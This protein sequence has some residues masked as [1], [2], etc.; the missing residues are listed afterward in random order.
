[1]A[2]SGADLSAWLGSLLR[3]ARPA[4]AL[5]HARGDGS[6]AG[7]G[8]ANRRAPTLLFA[9]AQRRRRRHPRARSPALACDLEEQMPG[10]PT[11]LARASAGCG[12]RRFDALVVG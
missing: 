7:A 8:A 1:V 6:A 2:G 5:L 4:P 12:D 11:S 3:P 10:R 9:S